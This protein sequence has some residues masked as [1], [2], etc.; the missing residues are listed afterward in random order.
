MVQLA[1]L[2]LYHDMGPTANTQA[3]PTSWRF[4]HNVFISDS[5]LVRNLHLR[6]RTKTTELHALHQIIFDLIAQNNVLYRNS[7]I[8]GCGPR[9]S[10]IALSRVSLVPADSPIRE[11]A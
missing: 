1:L 4:C 7:D 9:K 8:S 2:L 6:P 5:F 3:K 10:A 11:M